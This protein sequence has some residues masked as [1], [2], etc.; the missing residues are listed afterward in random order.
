MKITETVT[1]PLKSS[2]LEAFSERS[3][4]IKL[5]GYE[6]LALYS[7]SQRIAGMG[8][9]R[10]V[11]DGEKSSFH[12]DIGKIEG[13]KRALKEFEKTL[14]DYDDGDNDTVNTIFL[15]DIE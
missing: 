12:S 2:A 14:H 6:L 4:N 10:D 1:P 11:F 9:S 3:F 13:S 5:N 8:K 7:V 15:Q